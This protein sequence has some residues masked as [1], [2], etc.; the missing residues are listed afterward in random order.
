M[1]FLKFLKVVLLRRNKINQAKPKLTTLI[2]QGKPAQTAA[3]KWKPDF[4]KF[5]KLF[6]PDL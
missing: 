6:T 2:Y 5:A 3:D 1:N 4:Q